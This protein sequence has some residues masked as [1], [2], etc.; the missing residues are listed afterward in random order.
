M[1]IDN[2]PSTEEM[3]RKY[4]L[5]KSIKY[6]NGPSNA[7]TLTHA[8]IKEEGEL[9]NFYTSPEYACDLYISEFWKFLDKNI[10]GNS[11]LVWRAK[12]EIRFSQ[13]NNYEEINHKI[14]PKKQI[15]CAWIFSR[16]LIVP[17]DEVINDK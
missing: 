7:V 16:L 15:H 12:P 13:F 1:Q 8:G 9:C 6:I 11:E 4:P 2:F 3:L 5:I 17:F 10:K 14:Y